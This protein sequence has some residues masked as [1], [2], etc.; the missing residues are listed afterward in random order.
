MRFEGL[1]KELLKDTA[2][3]N[4]EVASEPAY[5]E[6]QLALEGKAGSQMGDAVIPAQPPNFKKAFEL[7]TELLGQSKHFSLLVS[8]ARAASGQHGFQGL[9]DSLAVMQGVS[10]EQWA[11]I[12]PQEDKDDPDDPWWERINLL[13]E[14]TD[15]P[16]TGDHLYQLKLVDV[17]HLGAF[18]K[19]DIDIAA[20]RREG[21]DEDKERCNP[22]LIR[23]AFSESKEEDLI[24]TD[25]A[26]AQ[27]LASCDSLDQLFT[28]NIGQDA[29]SFAVLKTRV[30]E[31]REAFREYA[32]DKLVIPEPVATDIPEESDPAESD[33]NGAQPVAASQP[34]PP[35]VSTAFA[36]RDAVA[37]AFDDVMLFYQ[38][39]E[40]S[41]P[42]PILL[43]R[44]R[45]MVYKN[46][47][48]ILRELAPQHKD[49]FR[50]LMKTLSDDPLGFLLE[51]SYNSFLNGESFEVASAGG[52]IPSQN[53]GEHSSVAESAV[54]ADG[55][56]SRSQVVQSLKDIQKFFEIKEPSSPVPLIV[57]RVITLVPKTFL[58]LL[59]EFEV[60]AEENIEA[61]G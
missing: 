42:V 37:A 49:N 50:E 48:D 27:V 47:F 9:A 10:S 59:A 35:V 2:A 45:Q 60:S 58:D 1:L 15:N 36:D 5:M 8:L 57:Q 26:M 40:P 52:Q 53:E 30:E 12:H 19:R 39:Y 23:G 3:G 56:T 55:I 32:A 25:E 6:L 29:P 46:F 20:G 34:A 43:F 38:K 16:A 18:S 22:N 4:G 24:A 11:E 33:G 61:S 44:A 14:L 51:H 28:T 54:E 31:C 41:S 13:R 17:K 21:T 7:C